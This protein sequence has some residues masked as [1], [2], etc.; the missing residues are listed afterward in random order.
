MQSLEICQRLGDQ[1]CSWDMFQE[2]MPGGGRCGYSIWQTELGK[3]FL[4]EP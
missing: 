4:L 2:H 1:V 3:N